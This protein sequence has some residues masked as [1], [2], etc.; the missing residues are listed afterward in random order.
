M[1][2]DETLCQ[3]ETRAFLVCSGM[4]PASAWECDEFDEATLSQGCDS[5]GAAVAT[6]ILDS[7]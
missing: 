6:C 5:E 7:F 2:W 4:A 1:T 3:T